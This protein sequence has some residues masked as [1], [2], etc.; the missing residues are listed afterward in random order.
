MDRFDYGE[1][2][3]RQ[4]PDAAQ[5]TMADTGRQATSA[6]VSVVFGI[7]WRLPIDENIRGPVSPLKT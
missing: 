6:F 7:S 4:Y 2:I 1:A 3:G 5:G